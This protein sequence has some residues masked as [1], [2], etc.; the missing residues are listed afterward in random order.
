MPSN[1]FGDAK[2][3]AGK[4]FRDGLVGEALDDLYSDIDG[5]FTAVEATVPA[6]QAAEADVAL[7]AVPPGDLAAAF[8]MIQTLETKINAILA[9]LRSANII[10][11]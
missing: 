9:K 8:V 6:E 1:A 5:A 10:A 11:E 2:R 4:K 3:P 7:G